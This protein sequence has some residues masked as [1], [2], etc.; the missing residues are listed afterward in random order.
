MSSDASMYFV[1]CLSPVHIGTGQ[2]V[3][4]IDLPI[5]RERT[6]EWPY[7]PGSG[8]KGVQRRYC[9]R[10]NHYSSD[11]VEAAFGRAAEGTADDEYS[12]VSESAAGALVITDGRLLAFPVA[13]LHGIF[14]YVTCPLALRR[15]MRDGEAAGFQMVDPGIANMEEQLG[16]N[17]QV[18]YIYQDSKLQAYKSDEKVTQ[19]DKT[20][21]IWLDEFRFSPR[22]S[23]ELDQ[24]ANWCA[25][26]LFPEDEAGASRLSW[27]GRLAVVSD[28]AFHYFV[29]MCSEITPRIRIQAD[30]KTVMDGALWYEEYVPS[31]AIFYGLLWCDQVYTKSQITADAIMSKLEENLVLQIGANISVGKGRVRYLLSKGGIV[32]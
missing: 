4:D 11:W 3:G 31:E 27:K 12:D 15:M 6:T 13:S 9:Q 21:D 5:I 17:T 29:T 22:H 28:E 24:W 32:R 30:T 18:A 14:A 23:P 7:L 10:S 25:E 8:M 16:V 26:Q 19:Q 1:H 2:G 20:N